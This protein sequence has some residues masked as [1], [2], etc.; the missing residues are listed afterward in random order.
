[1]VSDFSMGCVDLTLLDGRFYKLSSVLFTCDSHHKWCHSCFSGVTVHSMMI[2]NHVL[3]SVCIVLYLTNNSS[4]SCLICKDE[5]V[6]IRIL[7]SHDKLHNIYRFMENLVKSQQSGTDLPDA[8]LQ[9]TLWANFYLI[10]TASASTIC[11][12]Q[13]TWQ[14]FITVILLYLCK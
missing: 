9:K 10:I 8:P 3:I 4:A 7:K 1:M 13:M 2:V 5:N 11:H 14:F 6:K 12:D